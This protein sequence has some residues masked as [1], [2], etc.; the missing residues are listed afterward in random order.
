MRQSEK[1]KLSEILIRLED[2]LEKQNKALDKYETIGSVIP[3]IRYETK[4]MINGLKFA[5]RLITMRFGRP[6]ED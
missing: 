3:G 1:Q 5:I 4:G 6:F 2:A